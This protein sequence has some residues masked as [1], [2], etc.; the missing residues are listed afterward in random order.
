[1]MKQRN[2]FKNS[3]IVLALLTDFVR[4][5]GVNPQL[6]TGWLYPSGCRIHSLLSLR[7]IAFG[8]LVL[9]LLICSFSLWPFQGFG[10]SQLRDHVKIQGEVKMGESFEQTF[11]PGFSFSLEPNS[12]GWLLVIRDE[13][14]AEDIS[15][16][17]PPFHFVPNPREI[18]GWHFRNADNTG[19]NEPGEKNVNAPGLIREFIF[20]PEVGSTISGPKASGNVTPEEIEKVRSFGRGEMR[21]LEYRLQDLEPGKRAKFTWIRFEADLSWPAAS[22][23]E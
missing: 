9:L 4:W 13:Q 16:L 1:L 10:Q 14:K 8:F 21:I 23:K 19:S 20:S 5:K 22:K 3:G 12:F 18:E 15:R 11:G 17:T 6:A 2:R 7:P